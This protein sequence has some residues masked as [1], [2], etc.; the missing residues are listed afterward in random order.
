MAQAMATDITVP[1][2][3]SLQNAATAAKAGDRVLVSAGTFTQHFT[4]ANSGTVTAPLVFEAAAGAMPIIDGGNA[5][6]TI[7]SISG[8]YIVFRGFEVKNSSQHGIAITGDN[9][10][11]ENCRVSY[12]RDRGI[13]FDNCANASAIGCEVFECVRSNF[14]RS[15]SVTSGWG[16]GISI[17]GGSNW[18]VRNCRIHTNHGEGIGVWGNST[19]G[20]TQGAH[21]LHNEVYDNWSVNIWNDHGTAIEADGNLVYCTPN[22]PSPTLTRST[23]QGFLNAEELNFGLPGDLRNGVVTNNIVVNCSRGFGFWHDGGGLVG[24]LVANNTFVNNALSI[25]IDASPT[26]GS[27]V[28]RNNIFVQS[29]SGAM[30]SYTQTGASSVFSNNIWYNSSG[31]S[32]PALDPNSL[33][34]DPLFVGG[35]SL[36]AESY[37]LRAGSPCIAAGAKGFRVATDYWGTARPVGS[38][39]SIGAHEYTIP[40]QIL[41]SSNQKS[42]GLS[43][44]GPTFITSFSLSRS[45]SWER[46][47]FKGQAVRVR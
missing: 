27:N 9:V 42:P 7:V 32:L 12:A 45:G 47:N 38:P 14:P 2:G 39:S 18:V 3:G 34:R 28:F 11:V 8:R 26:N 46:R 4:I 33:F 17:R 20:G 21:I 44:Q 35:A 6:G 41:F 43:K 25:G 37:Q 15:E 10:T 31:G 16:M 1:P 13:N 30:L 36:V 40:N 29:V 5:G 24:F 23:P 19:T 22:R